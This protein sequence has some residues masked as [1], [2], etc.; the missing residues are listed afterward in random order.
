M[1][2]LLGARPRVLILGIGN[3][4]W[5]DDGFGVRCVE[6]LSARHAFDDQVHLLDGG[7]QGIYLVNLLEGVEHLI[8]F[9]AIDYGLPPGTLKVVRDDEVPRF[10]GAKK[11]SLHQ[12]GFQDVLAMA[13]LLG[14]LPPNM[15]LIGVQ[16]ERL[17]DYGGSLSDSVKAMIEP[18]LAEALAHLDA[19][20]IRPVAATAGGEPLADGAQPH[21]ALALTDYERGRPSTTQAWRHGDQ[22][23]LQT[24]S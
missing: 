7:T 15:L 1:T 14:Q 5:A 24:P 10:L 22:R 21:P 18:A 23:V 6:I 12:V 4:L 8:I 3:L 2:A 9:D 19:Q 17:E 20:G 16:P 11:M 13:E